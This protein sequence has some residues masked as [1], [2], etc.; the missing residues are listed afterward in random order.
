MPAMRARK[1]NMKIYE[2][3]S[4]LGPE[5]IAALLTFRSENTKLGAAVQLWV[6]LADEH[7]LDALRNGHD[8]SICGSCP[9]RPA[10]GPTGR[11]ERGCYVQMHPVAST[12]KSHRNKP[13]EP[14]TAVRG[15]L[16]KH[17]HTK[18]LRLGAYG[19]PAA[20]PYELL[21]ELVRTS[22][23]TGIRGV[24]GYTH[25]WRTCDSRLRHLCMASCEGEEQAMGWRTFTVH[26]DDLPTAPTGIWCPASEKGGFK[27]TCAVCRLCDGKRDDHD[28]RTNIDI[29]VHGAPSRLPG[30]RDAIQRSAA[31]TSPKAST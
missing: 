22:R 30:M 26:P 15:E 16:L 6:L 7:P 8:A 29:L 1:A 18:L 10:S 13:V 21:D 20:L 9:L 23:N 19:D 2:G 5:R 24:V 17:P 14:M 31:G 4:L 12:W 28:R 3:P 27:L 11:V 25:A